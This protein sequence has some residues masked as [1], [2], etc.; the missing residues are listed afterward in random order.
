M[1]TSLQHVMEKC[2]CPSR[3]TVMHCN[4]I[5]LAGILSGVVA[6]AQVVNGLY[7]GN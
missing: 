7:F 4:I 5:A 6:A 1:I 3:A 2:A